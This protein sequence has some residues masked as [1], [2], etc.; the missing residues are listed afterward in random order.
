MTDSIDHLEGATMNV[1]LTPS[2]LASQ[3]SMGRRAFVAGAAGV[4]LAALAACGPDGA[5]G[6]PGDA[7]TPGTGMTPG[8]TAPM[9]AYVPYD[10]V[11]PDLPGTAA[12][13]APG[14]Y[15]FPKPPLT[16]D[17]YPL[18]GIAPVTAL[19]QGDPPAVAPDKNKNYRL[20]AEQLGTSVETVFGSYANYQ[21]KFQVTMAGGDLPD[22]VQVISVTQLPRLLEANFTDLTEFLAGDAVKKYPGL[23]NIPTATWKVAT[24]NGRI[25]GVSRP[26]PPAGLVVNYRA[27]I[28]AERGVTETELQPQSGAEFLE[29]MKKLTDAGQGRFAMGADPTAWLIAIAK[30]MAGTPNGWAREGET[31]VSDIESPQMKDALDFAAQVWKA[32]CLHPNSFS[33]PAQNGVWYSSGVTA[34]FIRGFNGWDFNIRAN[35]DTTIGALVP[36][37]LAGGGPAPVHLTPAGYAAFVG[38]RKTEDTKRIEDLL[39]VF[40]YCASPFGTEQYLG[41]NYGV[42]GYSYTMGDDGNPAPIANAPT[43]PDSWTYA[44]GSRAMTLYS[45]GDRA[46]V[47]LRHDYMSSVLP[48]GIEDASTGLYSET[49]SGKAATMVKQRDDVVRQIIQGSQPVTAW[50]EYVKRWKSEIGDAMAAEY[51]EAAGH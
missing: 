23:A 7:T 3:R 42:E 35:P 19:L 30:Q 46:S 10:G 29:L 36:P 34:L 45:Q 49:A 51:A 11:T 40:D 6:G 25:W 26:Q 16:R 48:E 47:D 22:L 14:F 27:D 32:G 15:N 43:T 12:G 17:G 41:L 44:G 28:L 21:D 2:R 9:P 8:G 4:G 50:D 31:F 38:M 20:M 39:R 24:V 1:H 13:V 18:T 33:D 5:P 37:K